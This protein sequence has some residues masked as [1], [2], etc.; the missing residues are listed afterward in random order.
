MTSNGKSGAGARRDL[1]FRAEAVAKGSEHLVGRTTLAVP[2]PFFWYSIAA[3]SLIALVIAFLAFGSYT[4][5]EV[6]ESVIMTQTGLTRVKGGFEGVIA[7]LHVREGDRVRAGAP[8]VGLRV[9]RQAPEEDGI[10][11]LGDPPSAWDD[12]IKMESKVIVVKSPAA[13]VVYQLPM[14]VGN[15]YSEFYDVA[16]IATDGALSVTTQVSAAAKSRLKI[17][18]RVAMTLDAYKGSPRARI[19][20]RVASVALSPTEMYVRETRATLRTYKAV[21]QLDP[22]QPGHANG[23]LLGKTV[24]VKI[25]VQKRK[26]YQWL[27]DP[28]KSLFGDG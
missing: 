24:S 26:M 3:L 25:P 13:G 11:A 7:E 19:V 28:L 27:F 8:L 2:L 5:T 20:G 15:A 12:G 21:I 4:K 17:G 9:E 18:D 23:T 14:N 6:S 22:A 16:V 1:G 10:D